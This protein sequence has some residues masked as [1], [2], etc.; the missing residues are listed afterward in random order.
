LQV[1]W[2]W[3]AGVLVAVPVG[4]SF[5]CYGILDDSPRAPADSSRVRAFQSLLGIRGADVVVGLVFLGL[6][7]YFTYHCLRS[8]TATGKAVVSVGIALCGLAVLAAWVT[9]ALLRGS[10]TAWQRRTA[11]DLKKLPFGEPAEEKP[12]SVPVRDKVL[13]WDCTTRALSP[14]QE[15]LPAGRRPHRDDDAFTV[16]LILKTAD[17][18]TETYTSGEV[19]MTRTMTLGVV[20]WPERKVLGC[21]LLSGEGPGWFVMRNAGDKGPIIGNTAEPLKNWLESKGASRYPASRGN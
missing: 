5:V 17:K 11:D 13:V 15:L 7:A 2:P 16:V 14:A 10:E 20:D 1:R 8:A 6:A 21:Y 18:Q 9:P 12:V 19:G 3:F 4:L